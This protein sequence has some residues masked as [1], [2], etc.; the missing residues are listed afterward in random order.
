M[1]KMIG[2]LIIMTFVLSSY[3]MA[4][5][6]DTTFRW[7]GATGFLSQGESGPSND[8]F[9]TYGQTFTINSSGNYL[10]S[11]SVFVND[12]PFNPYPGNRTHFD[13]NIYAWDGDKITGSEIY[14]SD[15]VTTIDDGDFHEFQFDVNKYLPDGDYVF[16]GSS[17]RYPDG[18]PDRAKWGY[19]VINDPYP[20]GGD[21]FILGPAMTLVF[22][23]Q[24]IG[25]R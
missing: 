18:N 9:S 14:K 4:Y 24:K 3:A 17:S 7:D 21:L 1:K 16:L 23:R 10:Q 12:Y 25:Q 19:N 20:G 6:I 22:M 15:Q 11:L 2:I 5:E 13:L 8:I